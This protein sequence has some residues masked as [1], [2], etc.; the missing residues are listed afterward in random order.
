MIDLSDRKS[1]QEFMLINSAQALS[2]EQ[3]ARFKAG[4]EAM[5]DDMFWQVI[6]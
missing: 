6:A 2:R 3:Y 1:F 5:P 4:L